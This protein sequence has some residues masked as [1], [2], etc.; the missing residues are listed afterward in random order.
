[1]NDVLKDAYEQ[2]RKQGFILQKSARNKKHAHRKGGYQDRVNEPWEDDA[3]GYVA[4][5]PP[6]LIIV[7]NDCYQDDG[8]SFK[9]FCKDIGNFELEPFATTPSGGEHYAFLN[10]DPDLVV[11]NLNKK[12]PA[13]DI[14]AGYQS[15]VPIVGT[16]VLNKQDELASYKWASFDD[17]FI[18]NGVI[19]E[20]LKEVLEMRPRSERNAKEY[21]DLELSIVANEMP[22][23]EVT[24]LI[25][26][27]PENLDYDTW[28]HVGMALYDRYGGSD[29]GFEHFDR[30]SQQSSEKYDEDFTRKKW[31]NGHVI[32]DAITYKRLRS[33]SNES[34]VHEVK[35][36]IASAEEFDDIIEEVKSKT[37][38]NVGGEKDE[39]VRLKIAV[40]INKRMKELKIP[41][42]QARTIVKEMLPSR[43]TVITEVD[44]PWLEDLVYVESFSNSKF[45]FTKSRE[46]LS[47]DGANGRLYSELNAL[48]AKLGL[49]TC[50]VKTLVS[51][52]MIKI[53]SNHEYNPMV[54]DIVYRSGS[55]GTILNTYMA[56]SRPSVA[57]EFTEEGEELIKSFMAHLKYLITDG[58]AEI[59]LDWLAYQAQN[60]GTKLLWTPLI[61]SAEGLGKSLI[62]NAM[63]NNVFGE[64]NSGTVDSNVVVGPNTSWAS[65]GVFQ[66]L[67][68][69][70]LAGHNRFE[71]LNQLKPFITNKTVSRTEKYEVS[72]EVRN[73]C[74]FIALTNFKDAIPVSADDRRWW[75]VF[76]KVNTIDD[77]ETLTGE[78]RRDYFEPLHQ[79]ANGKCGD[80][81]HKWML[82]RDLSKF[83]PNFPPESIHKA[84]MIA[85]E[86]S[87]TQNLSD[88]RELIH[89]T[90]KGVT[91][92]VVSSK[93]LRKL[94]Q[95]PAWEHESLD[96]NEIVKLLRALGYSKFPDKIKK[97]GE[98]HSVWFNEPRLSDE[99]VRGK[100]KKAMTL[101]VEDGF[102]DLTEEEQ[103]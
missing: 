4:I 47:A 83:N 23:D 11:G 93:E 18:I 44:E 3:T 19:H 72:A 76:A 87:K 97:D 100:F 98:L 22:E 10:T 43:E 60:F 80:Q 92:E 13:L 25:D 1:M 41:V 52:N 79:L 84:R 42:I 26:G 65:K 57:E 90:S 35:E 67:E 59:L 89:A 75:V 9:Q 70:K 51:R 94:T 81:F 14:Y 61:Q 28:L 99:E 85:T 102:D 101:P 86:E 88:L 17:S 21:D 73:Y 54:D 31:Y 55:G 91:K 32:P 39:D 71:V 27:M 12:Y 29:E 33:I 68:E 50:T 53:C 103:S 69:I 62:G 82:E 58:E 24:Q 64:G 36:R 7:D 95:S 2:Y 78:N 46:R 96:Y 48:K 49:K 5:I 6:S 15:V 16:T 8:E 30:F 63:I 20:T 66:V 74:N 38:L 40:C 37:W 34:F 45:Y 56:D 77:L